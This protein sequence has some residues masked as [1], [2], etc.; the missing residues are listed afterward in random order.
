MNSSSTYDGILDSAQALAQRL[1]FNAFSYADIAAEL[2]IRKA[3]IHYHFPSKRDLEAELLRRYRTGFMAKLQTISTSV[4]GNEQQLKR[5][6]QLYATTLNDDRI[7][8]AGMMASDIG[9]LSEDLRNS[10]QT[11]FVQQV[12]WLTEVLNA[13]K[14]SGEFTFT[15]PAECQANAFL[16]ALQGGLLMANAMG[17]KAAFKKLTQTLIDKIQ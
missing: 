13:G 14:S 1:G 12:D 2:G 5:Y 4:E 3:S 9:A 11:F 10:L 6:A 15:G 17:D 7:C 8:L 16:S